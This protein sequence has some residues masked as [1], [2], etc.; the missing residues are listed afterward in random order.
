MGSIKQHQPVAL[1]AGIMAATPQLLED[2]CQQL[3]GQYGPLKM[4]SE[5]YPF[6]FTEY[7]TKEMGAGLLKQFVAFE[8]MVSPEEVAT[9]KLATND[10]EDAF[11]RAAGAEENRCVNIDPGYITRAKLV[12]V[13]TKDYAHRL[14][15]SHGIYAEV[16]LRFSGPKNG[17]A[18]MPW[19]YADYQT[20]EAL[21]YFK[22]VRTWYKNKMDG[23][24]G[25]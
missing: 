13:T 1:I 18:P 25:A 21:S 7:Y 24:P 9:I 2:A 16:T 12:L 11:A 14:Y 5:P 23:V 15:I 10:M 4:V 6:S 8:N 19:T 3:Q 17:F 22:K 20:P